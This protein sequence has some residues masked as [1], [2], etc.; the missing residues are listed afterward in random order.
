[1]KR[2]LFCLQT[3]VRGGVEKELI[4]LSKILLKNNYEVTL[5]ILYDSNNEMVNEFRKIGVAILNLD[6]DR[7][8]YCGGNKQM[9]IKRIIRGHLWEAMLFAF[10]HLFNIGCSEAN[11]NINNMQSINIEYDYAVC[12]HIHSPIMIKYVLNK[13]KAKQKIAWIH[14]D[15]V[16][17][18]YRV[19]RMVKY[20][21]Q[22][23]M[24]VSVSQQVQNEFLELCPGLE[25]KAKVIH[26]ILDIEDIQQK[27]LE[28]IADDRFK[29]NGDISI[30]TIGRL[31]EQK[32][33]DIAIEA[34]S[35][36]IAKGY[37]VVWFVIGDGECFDFLNEKVRNYNL[38]KQF[39]FLGEKINPYPFLK[40]CDIYVQPSR[41]EGYGLA[42]AEARILHKP[43][44]STNFAGALEQLE[45]EKNGLIIKVND[46]DGLVH[47]VE[48]LLDERKRLQ[49]SENLM[50]S[51]KYDLEIKELLSCFK[52]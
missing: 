9:F 25:S 39:V 1:M 44:I 43:I 13:T 49:L 15:F 23:S 46:I 27:S 36:L 40:Q 3:L 7:E 45:N 26:N 33:I 2:I 50:N 8:Y 38:T 4:V 47:A 16:T 17:T 19:D 34:C 42:V 24:I 35:K 28:P 41:H 48:N 10:K 12:Y 22:Y 20:L 5:A 14:N 11:I 52:V 29:I 18:G 32:G 37:K 30:L 31:T 21:M 6:I 51:V